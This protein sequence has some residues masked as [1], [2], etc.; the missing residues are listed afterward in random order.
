MKNAFRRKYPPILMS[1]PFLTERSFREATE[2]KPQ[3]GGKSKKSKSKSN[4]KPK[5]KKS[6]TM[7]KW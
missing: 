5:K 3:K 2:V 6:K 7:K 4:S 1:V